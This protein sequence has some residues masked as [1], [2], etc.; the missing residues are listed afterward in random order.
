MTEPK[1]IG[2]A[3]AVAGGYVLGRNKKGRL[4]LA[5]AGLLLGRALSPGEQMA[6][7]LHKLGGAASAEGLDESVRAD[8]AR[9][10]R[11]VVSGVTN[12]RLTSL[13]EALR[14]R[15]LSLTGEEDE[16]DEAEDED[17]EEGEEGEEGDEEDEG[18]DDEEPRRGRSHRRETGSGKRPSGTK[19]SPPAKKT[20]GKS[21][22]KSAEQKSTGKK[23]AAPAKKTAEKKT[24][25]AKKSASAKKRTTSRSSQGR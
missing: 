21:A 9:A 16:E 5:A 11:K 23:K 14:E 19:G 1:K 8:I 15:T 13:T 7:Q 18:E 24:A 4:A 20:A 12:R 3:A 25:P 22:K 2:L 6:K 10:A 17:D